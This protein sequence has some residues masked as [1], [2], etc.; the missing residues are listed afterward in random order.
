MKGS[1]KNRNYRAKIYAVLAA[2]LSFSLIISL[3]NTVLAS[4]ATEIDTSVDVAIE[5]WEKKVVGTQKTDRLC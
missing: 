2:C 3:A 5:R 1:N 4:S